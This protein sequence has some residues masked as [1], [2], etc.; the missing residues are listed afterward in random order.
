[1][2]WFHLKIQSPGLFWKIRR[3]GSTGHIFCLATPFG[4]GVSFLVHCDPNTQ[5]VCS[6]P[7]SLLNPLGLSFSSIKQGDG[8]CSTLDDVGSSRRESRG[9]ALLNA[10]GIQGV[11]S[12]WLDHPA[13]LF[14]AS[15]NMCL[16]KTQSKTNAYSR[17]VRQNVDFTEVLLGV[18][19]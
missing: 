9:E 14:K 17:A 4:R 7:G 5:P 3:T 2:G 1:M 10:G 8:V 11:S 12:M 13:F 16:I 19:R 15:V 6:F 18:K